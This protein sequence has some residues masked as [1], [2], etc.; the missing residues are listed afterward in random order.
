[1][2]VLSTRNTSLIVGAKDKPLNANFISDIFDFKEM[3]IG[4]IQCVRIDGDAND[5]VFSLEIS[6]ICD[7]ESFAPYPSSEVSGCNER[8]IIWLFDKIPFRF[9]RLIYTA[10][11]DTTGTVSVYGRGK[12]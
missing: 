3:N 4:S 11:T 9:A 8:N 6:N 10:G 7:E 1:M 12:K 2:T 5:G